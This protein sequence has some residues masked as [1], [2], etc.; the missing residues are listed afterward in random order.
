[1]V[2]TRSM[3]RIRKTCTEA[4]KHWRLYVFLLIPLIYLI[5]FK[6]VPMVGLQIAFRDFK[7]NLGMSG[8]KW[9]GLKH[10]GKFIDSFYFNRILRNNVL[11]SLYGTFSGFAISIVFAL[12]LNSV[13]SKRFR[14]VIENITYIP[15]FISAVV[16]VGIIRQVLDV[17]SGLFATLWTAIVGT[18][19]PN[20][21]ESP[22]LF[23]HLYVW[24]GIWQST[25]W[26]S[27]IYVAALSDVN[28][29]LH[30]AAELDG[31][32]RFS[33]LIHIDLPAIVP[34]ITITLI[35]A[36]GKIMEIGFDKIYLMQN[37]MNLETSEVFSTYV[38]KVGLGSGGDFSYGA[39]IG[40]LQS[41]T[42]LILI[43][44]VNKIADRINGN[45]LW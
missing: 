36:C 31:A 32:G 4:A 25:G 30:E 34:T 11:L 42:N 13:I 35:L 38:Y 44:F 15:H 7:A 8:S 5:T 45:S 41:V 6:Y 39:A 10:F 37:S 17:H 19:V 22:T 16:M 21:M 1:M 27:I 23:P 2:Q 29:E 28:P 24:S 3:S 33:R 12:E 14:S 9:V 18:D 20:L 43:L 40:L 26:S